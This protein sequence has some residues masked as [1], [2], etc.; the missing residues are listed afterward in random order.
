MNYSIRINGRYPYIIHARYR[1]PRTG[2]TYSF[3]S[4]DVWTD[5]VLSPASLK[6][7]RVYVQKDDYRVSYVDVESIPGI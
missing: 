1:N 2:E 4:G 6:T 3:K 5:F 7:V